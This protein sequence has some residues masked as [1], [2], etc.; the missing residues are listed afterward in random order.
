MKTPVK[1]ISESKQAVIEK[2][3]F[4][5]LEYLNHN[6]KEITCSAIFEALNIDLEEDIKERVMENLKKQHLIIENIHLYHISEFGKKVIG[7]HIG[8]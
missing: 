5:I 3:E 2:I 6:K 7:A 8:Q 1:S 4:E